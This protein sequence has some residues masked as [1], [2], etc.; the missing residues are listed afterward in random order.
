[1]TDSTNGW[2]LSVTRHIAASP[3]VVWH[4]MTERTTEWFCPKPWRFEIVEQDRRPGGREI[5]IIRGPNGEEMRNDGI[6]LA[7]EPGKRFVVTDALTAEFVPQGPFMVGIFEIEPEDGGTRYTARA[8]HWTEEAM[9]Q[10]QDMGF[11]PGWAI[12][13]EQLKALCEEAT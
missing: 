8:R 12:C 4:V 6:Y 5:S 9:K 7:Y 1:M 11:E 2:E 13:A 10:H 3:D